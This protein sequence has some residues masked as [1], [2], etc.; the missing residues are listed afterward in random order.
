V[1]RSL[2]ILRLFAGG[3]LSLSVV[4]ADSIPSGTGDPLCEVFW[5]AGGD[6]R[7]DV[8]RAASGRGGNSGGGDGVPAM[9]VRG[10]EGALERGEDGRMSASEP[11][12]TAMMKVDRAMSVWAGAEG[13]RGA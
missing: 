5:E 2:D 7:Y 6:M 12:Q 3:G 13:G 4:P 10:E 11:L 9:E 1:D 8:E